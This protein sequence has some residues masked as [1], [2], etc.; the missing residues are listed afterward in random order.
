MSPDELTHRWDSTLAAINI[1][2]HEVEKLLH[3][4]ITLS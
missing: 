2:V 1:A 4:K 3:L